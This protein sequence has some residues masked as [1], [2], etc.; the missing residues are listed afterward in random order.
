MEGRIRSLLLSAITLLVILITPVAQAIE[1]G[2]KLELEPIVQP[3][4]Q[5]QDF[6]EAKINVDDFEIKGFV[7]FLSVEDFG[8]NAVLGGSVSYHVSE[9]LFIDATLGLSKAGKTSYEVIGQG[10]LISDS[11]RT[12]SYY[13][14][15]LGYD[16]FPGEAFMT[17]QL[18]YNTALYVVAGIGSTDFAGDSHFTLSF[19]FGYRLLATNTISAYIDVRDHTFN[20]DILGTDKLTHNLEITIGISTYF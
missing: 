15:S 9:S 12:L 5:R 14:I 17:D 13:L 11:D 8:V 6:D 16:L 7:G 4:I 20:M 2:D 3:D 18:T 10:N 19:G 1:L